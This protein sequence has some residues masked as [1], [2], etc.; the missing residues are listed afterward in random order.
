MTINI[1]DQFRPLT[2]IIININGKIHP[3][4]NFLIWLTI[5]SIK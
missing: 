3:Y 5:L 1:I 4:L 2:L